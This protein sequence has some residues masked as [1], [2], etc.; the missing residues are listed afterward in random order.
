MASAS[1]S[2]C[3]SSSCPV[4]RSPQQDFRRCVRPADQPEQQARAVVE[5]STAP[6]GM[7]YIHTPRVLPLSHNASE[8]T[9][10]YGMKAVLDLR[11][12]IPMG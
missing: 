3:A 8:R 1:P 10:V 11:P 7:Y 12:V 5:Q 9:L 6:A 4:A 2:I